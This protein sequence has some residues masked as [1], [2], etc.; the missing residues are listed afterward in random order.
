MEWL[1]HRCNKMNVFLCFRILQHHDKVDLSFDKAPGNGEFKGTK[2][3]NVYLTNQRVSWPFISKHTECKKRFM[4]IPMSDIAVLDI[5]TRNGLYPLLFINVRYMFFK[6]SVYVLLPSA[7]ER[8]WRAT[9]D[10]FAGKIWAS[11]EHRTKLE[12]EWNWVYRIH[13]CGSCPVCVRTVL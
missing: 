12:T 6:C 7:K 1:R 5:R 3:G 8:Y 4:I 2:N 9:Y 11:S 10:K 13:M